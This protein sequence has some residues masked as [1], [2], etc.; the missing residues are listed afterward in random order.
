M[1]R[2]TA[3]CL[4]TAL[5]SCGVANAEIGTLPAEPKPAKLAIRAGRLIDVRTGNVRTDAIILVEN[6]K[7]ASISNDIP[8]GIPLID[9]SNRTVL[10]G[11]IDCHV[12]LLSNYA[13]LSSAEVLR[14]SSAQATLRGVHY[15]GIY[16]SKGFTTLRDAGE[17][18][19]GYGS[20]RSATLCSRG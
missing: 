9:L 6:G 2:T 16:L 4:A 15:L 18:Y 1:Y 3:A 5:L 12:H 8:A 13:D 19:A 14:E 10:P 17:D 20:S 11:F 7:I